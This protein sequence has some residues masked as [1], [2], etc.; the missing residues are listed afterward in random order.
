[1]SANK[2]DE[3]YDFIV[4]YKTKHEGNSP[5]FAEIMEGC[6]LNSTSQVNYY[7]DQLEIEGRIRRDGVK[8]IYIGGKWVKE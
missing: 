5:S 4:E 3:V 2:K 6:Q 1:M 8:S 7:L